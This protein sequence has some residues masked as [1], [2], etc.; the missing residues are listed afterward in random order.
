VYRTMV[1]GLVPL[2]CIA[3]LAV[4][5]GAAQKAGPVAIEFARGTSSKALTG[6]L[7]GRQQMDYSI[8]GHRS[9]TMRLRMFDTPVGSLSLSVLDMNGTAFETQH[10]KSGAETLVLPADGEYLI[11]IARTLETRGTSRYRLRIE[12]K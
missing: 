9:Q 7:S 3:I 10:Q 4:N 11:R 1:K 12:I 8:A 5:D 6:T 2:I